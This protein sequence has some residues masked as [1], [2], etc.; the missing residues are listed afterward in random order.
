VG[1][2]GNKGARLR[3]YTG[4]EPQLPTSASTGQAVHELLRLVRIEV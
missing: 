4:P 2:T 3:A 1:L